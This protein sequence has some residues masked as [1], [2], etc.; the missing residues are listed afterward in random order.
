MAEEAEEVSPLV[1]SLSVRELTLNDA[2]PSPG[3]FPRM[4]HM[5]RA[6]GHPRAQSAYLSSSGISGVEEMN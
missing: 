6:G 5:W 2:P 4:V 1:G 3:V